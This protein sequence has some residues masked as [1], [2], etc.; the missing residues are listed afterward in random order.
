MFSGF[1]A[2][3]AP[4]LRS[5]KQTW[6]NHGGVVKGLADA[7]IAFVTDKTS[8]SESSCKPT[9]KILRPDWIEDS[10]RGQ[11]RLSL[12]RYKSVFPGLSRFDSS[13]HSNMAVG[14]DAFNSTKVITLDKSWQPHQP[15][16]EIE[17]LSVTPSSGGASSHRAD[18]TLGSVGGRRIQ[19]S[20]QQSRSDSAST[21]GV[22]T[23]PLTIS[24]TEKVVDEE[25]EKVV[26]EEAEKAV[27]EEAEKDEIA[28]RDGLEEEPVVATQAF[29]LSQAVR[30]SDDEYQS[31]EQD[32]STNSKEGV[33]IVD[34]SAPSEPRS[35]LPERQ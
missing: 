18:P 1:S 5:Y 29:F 21:G 10:V 27:N 25:V 35:V 3:F 19:S 17:D 15:E 7:D 31:P 8:S 11:K 9:M 13:E 2:W 34:D 20:F 24:E 32:V 22:R 4:E 14:M 28:G 26:D 12:K 16:P 33:E 23:I 6:V 30:S